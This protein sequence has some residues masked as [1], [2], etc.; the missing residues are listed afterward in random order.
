MLPILPKNIMYNVLDIIAKNF[1]GLYIFYE[2]IKLKRGKNH[3][4]IVSVLGILIFSAGICVLGESIIQKMNNGN[5]VLIGTI[6]LALINA[7][8]CLMINAKDYR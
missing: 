5:W 1:Y 2:I 4:L 3:F 8:I 6:A 7:G